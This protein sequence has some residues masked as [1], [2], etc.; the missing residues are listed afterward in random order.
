MPKYWLAL[1]LNVYN[2]RKS[3]C[4]KSTKTGQMF[5]KISQIDFCW[6]QLISYIQQG[7]IKEITEFRAAFVCLMYTTVE[8]RSVYESFSGKNTF[9]LQPVN[10]VSGIL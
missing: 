6:I 1:I 7:D 4:K 9:W 2:R 5:H 8:K 3:V 10:A